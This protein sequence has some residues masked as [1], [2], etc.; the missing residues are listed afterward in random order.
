MKRSL[1]SLKAALAG[2]SA[3]VL[4]AVFSAHGAVPVPPGY[5]GGQV[6]ICFAGP[7]TFHQYRTPSIDDPA[8][9]VDNYVYGDGPYVTKVDT[10]DLWPIY[11]AGSPVLVTA[12]RMKGQWEGG[13]AF[14]ETVS[15]GRM[16]LFS[17][18]AS[19]DLENWSLC[20]KGRGET[21]SP[22]YETWQVRDPETGTMTVYT[23]SVIA[24]THDDS[25]K[26]FS[27]S[28]R[29]YRVE[30]SPK[31]SIPYSDHRCINVSE[32]SLWTE[33]LSVTAKRPMP[34]LGNRALNTGDA[35]FAAGDDPEGVEFAGVLACAPSGSSDIHV[36]VADHDYGADYAAWKAA[37]RDIAL[38]SGVASGSAFSAKAVLPDGIWFT[39]IFAVS[40]KTAAPAQVTYRVAVGTEAA[41]PPCHQ[42]NSGTSFEKCYDGNFSTL[43]DN[44]GQ[45]YPSVWIFDC[46]KFEGVY[47]A[48]IRFWRRG[49]TLWVE[50]LRTRSAV[51]SVTSD[52]I[53]WPD[54]EADKSSAARTYFYRQAETGADANWK[55]VEDM[56]WTQMD[57]TPSCYDIAI[58]PA[59]ARKAKYVKITNIG[60]ASAC[61]FEI[62]TLRRNGTILLVR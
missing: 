54:D 22:S 29:Y 58:P 39:R 16:G 15:T 53:A 30:A 27:T 33:S 45:G 1:L 20:W 47:P 7:R 35:T 11:D 6:G 55:Q 9:L 46:S 62:R 10:S 37:G 5:A 32:F 43:C 18:Y 19:N 51:V 26:P 14:S 2:F 28:W 42:S 25:D 21:L 59:L 36:C 23:N 40:G 17:V 60:F 24:A 34:F 56:S 8:V 49:S 38:A 61:E 57:V 41:Y 52:D 31:S 44:D 48:S 50:Y 12:I 13:E 3:T 4:S